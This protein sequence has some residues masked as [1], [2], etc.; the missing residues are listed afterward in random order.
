MPRLNVG[1]KMPNFVFD[2]GFKQGL[3][4]DTDFV[5]KKT[6]LWVLRYIG[7]TVCRYDCK[8]IA[9]RYDEFTAKGAQVY[10]LM[11][12]DP[13]HIKD[14]LERTN[15]TL[16]FEIICD[17]EMKIYEALEI[18]PAESMEALLGGQMEKLKVK[19]AAAK[20]AGFSHGDYEGNEQ[21][22]PAMFILD[23]EGKATY[24]R[25]AENIVDLPTVDEVL[26]LL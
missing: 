21:Q 25:Y 14:D 19:G 13:Q 20:E 2:T 1:E 17:P 10:V 15:A 18:K 3:S 8:L 6:V 4:V 22:L 9:D 16:P 5:G 23:E 11:Q 24:V 26:E 7:C 12:S